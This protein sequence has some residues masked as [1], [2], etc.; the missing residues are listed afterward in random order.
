MGD[1]LNG[2][3][4]SMSIYEFLRRLEE[5]YIA[6]LQAQEVKDDKKALAVKE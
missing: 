4:P 3:I 5:E 2:I 6:D 1:K